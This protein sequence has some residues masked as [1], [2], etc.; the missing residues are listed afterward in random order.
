MQ[1][2]ER[3]IKHRIKNAA[4][5]LTAKLLMATAW[6]TTSSFCSEISMPPL[7]YLLSAAMKENL[8]RLPDEE[9]KARRS[10]L[11]GDIDLQQA[12]QNIVALSLL[13]ISKGHA[14]VKKW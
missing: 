9:L 3:T 11:V 14:R 5:N 12:F 7:R 2:L 10:E 13:V 6:C 4:I 8:N 1:P